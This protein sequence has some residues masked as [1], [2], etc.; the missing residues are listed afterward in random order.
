MGFKYVIWPLELLEDKE[1]LVSKDEFWCYIEELHNAQVQNQNDEELC[2][3]MEWVNISQ[4][5]RLGVIPK[6]MLRAFRDV[7]IYFHDMRHPYIQ[8]Q[9]NSDIF[10]VL[11]SNPATA[12]ATATATSPRPRPLDA[13]FVERKE[14]RDVPMAQRGQ[15]YYQEQYLVSLG[16]NPFTYPWPTQPT[17]M[18]NNNNTTH[19]VDLFFRRRPN[20]S[21]YPYGG[22]YIRPF[23]P[24]GG[25]YI[26][27]F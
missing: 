25:F 14:G 6:K 7:F 22:F 3:T 15:E 23:Y 2:R 17:D 19:P 26:R 4:P 11:C 21:L 20:Y 5:Y 10:V 13:I 8:A 24:N 12:T 9:K 1:I 27:P 18:H 16:R